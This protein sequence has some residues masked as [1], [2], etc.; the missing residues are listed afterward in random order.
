MNKLSLFDWQSMH[1]RKE[2][3]DLHKIVKKN[4]AVD[5][6]LIAELALLYIGFALDRAF[7]TAEG[8]ALWAW[9]AIA[10]IGCAIIL[11]VWGI[12]SIPVII[13]HRRGKWICSE[14][15]IVDLID[16]K[17]CYYLMTA[18]TMMDNGIG[19]NDEIGKFYL[20]ETSYYANKCV[21]I[22]QGVRNNLRNA[23][24]QSMNPEEYRDLK[25]SEP[26][27]SNIL[28]ILIGIY[29]NLQTIYGTE[30]QTINDKNIEKVRTENIYFRKELEAIREELR[31]DFPEI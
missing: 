16:N 1:L 6:A 22:L 5:F 18:Q 8:G 31:E 15:D 3:E 28:S 11:C 2:V 9:I 21:K 10:V 17:L 30:E 13:S 26:R 24:T 4:D 19:I 23:I 7:G 14:R 20:I 25:I 12:K 27:M 29:G